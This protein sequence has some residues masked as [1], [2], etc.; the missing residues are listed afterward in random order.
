MNADRNNLPNL[1][2]HREP[3]PGEFDRAQIDVDHLLA[4]SA[5]AESQLD[6]EQGISS[7]LSQRIFEMTASSL[8]TPVQGEAQPRLRLVEAEVV[9][10]ARD[11]RWAFA[12]WSRFALAASVLLVAGL[13]LWTT[14]PTQSPTLP[15]AQGEGDRGPRGATAPE[16]R[17]AS[18]IDLTDLNH[19]DA[20]NPSAIDAYESNFS[21]LLDAS[22]V[23]S[24]NDLNTD[25][26]LFVAQMEM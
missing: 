22:E 25:L 20:S 18:S 11:S 14:W 23:R 4:H 9:Q 21:Y 5:R 3:L 7:G 16:V 13:T 6:M 12:G 19:F 8:P 10:V 15:I 17:T 2:S 24:F 1:Q 26:R